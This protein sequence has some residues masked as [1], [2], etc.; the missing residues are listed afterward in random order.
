MPIHENKECPN[1]NIISSNIRV[2]N[3]VKEML[4]S[5]SYINPTFTFLVAKEKRKCISTSARTIKI[6][7]DLKINKFAASARTHSPVRADATRVC[8]DGK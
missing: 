8:A 4:P 2:G 7:K 1:P 5:A 6:K 3:L